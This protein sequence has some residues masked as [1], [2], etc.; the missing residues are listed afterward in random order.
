MFGTDFPCD[1]IRGNMISFGFGWDLVT[2]DHLAAMNITHC[3][4]RPTFA[5]YETLRA[6]K[7][8]ASFE[9]YGPREIE[10]IFYHNAIR[11]VHPDGTP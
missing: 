7:R 2:A 11:F 1:L 9:G 10:D 8:A 6:F 4:P 5:H 3:D